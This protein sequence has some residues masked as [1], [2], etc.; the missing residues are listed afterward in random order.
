M[1]TD[2]IHEGE[3]VSSRVLGLLRQKTVGDRIT[4]VSVAEELGLIGK[5]ADA[6]SA[7]MSKHRLNGLYRP[8]HKLRRAGKS[9]QPTIVYEIV[10]PQVE[11]RVY[12]TMRGGTRARRSG[13]KSKQISLPYSEVIN[14]PKKPLIVRSE[15]SL[16]DKA[17]AL[18]VDIETAM[19]KPL[20][21][22]ST[23]ELLEE[24]RRRK[25]K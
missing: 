7:F 11:I 18:A 25:K 3:T 14:F 12:A 13:Y 2:P 8:I 9:G 23:Q 22:F 6:V 21:A 19:A 15:K 17:L 24:L 16:V 1:L 20:S 10:N 5:Q 4:S